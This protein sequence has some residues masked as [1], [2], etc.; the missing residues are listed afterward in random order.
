MNK[1]IVTKWKG[2][3]LTA[4]MSDSKCRSLNLE[5]EES[6]SLLGNIYIGK[7]QNIV[8]NINAAFVDLGGGK[9]GYYSLTEN[10][11][12]LFADCLPALC[13]DRTVKQG[14]ELVVQ[15]ARDAVK[16][17]DPVLSSY[18][19]FTGK[20]AVLTMGKNQVGFSVKI[21]DEKWKAEIKE[22]LDALKDER[23]GVIVRTNAM[24]A[25]KETIGREVLALKERM[26]ELLSKAACRTC[27]S[28]LE[29]AEPS[30]IAGLRDTFAGSLEAI[31][32]DI[33]ECHTRMIAYLEENQPDDAGKLKFYEDSAVPLI[34]LYS[35]ESAMEEAS[36]RRVWLK[37][38]GYLV[39]EPTEAL[40]V[41]DVN[42]GKYTGKKNVEDT[43][44]KI[45]LE[46]AA[47]TARQ[48]CLRNLSGI[49]IVDFID[50]TKEE[51]KKLLLARLEEELRKD[52]VKTVLVEM[53]KLGLVEITRKKVRRPFY[54]M[55]KESVAQ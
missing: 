23:F 8:K 46:A 42:T 35:L 24:G 17:K 15:V 19:N 52:P 12:H 36:G 54:E 43:I 9:T 55:L 3:I 30:Y 1:L 38:G 44:L 18:L 48:L 49:I 31:I 47:E 22:Y 50:M 20:Y 45:N 11:T 41:V 29:S 53:T 7:V 28:V 26:E 25:A 33:P 34:K 5:Q 37:S 51:H 27:Y 6:N 21:R 39:I 16:T 13:P 2:M 14:D 40:T 32:T 4:L 10:R